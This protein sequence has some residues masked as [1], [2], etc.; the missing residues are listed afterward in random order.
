[1]ETIYKTVEL[2]RPWWKKLKDSFYFEEVWRHFHH[3]YKALSILAII[4]QNCICFMA[5]VF[6]ILSPWPILLQQSLLVFIFTGCMTFNFVVFFGYRSRSILQLWL[7][8]VCISN[9]IVLGSL[10]L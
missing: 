3:N 6:L 10:F 1:M 8:N 5:L 4:I 9:C 7:A 2:G